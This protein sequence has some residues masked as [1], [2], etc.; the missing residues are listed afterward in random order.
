M[1]S[2][3]NYCDEV[4]NFKKKIEDEIELQVSN[5]MLQT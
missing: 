1:F 3:H 5:T 4:F 2:Y